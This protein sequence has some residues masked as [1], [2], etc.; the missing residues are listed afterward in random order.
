MDG[1]GE[2]EGMQSRVPV[3]ELVAGMEARQAQG[4]GIGYGSGPLLL[5]P[6][7]TQRRQQGIRAS[8]RVLAQQCRDN[9]V[10]ARTLPAPAPALLQRARQRLE[11]VL[12]NGYQVYGV[13]P[14]VRLLH[15][16]CARVG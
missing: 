4:G 12:Q 3:A 16:A 1:V 13:A 2:R 9:F 8:L 7:L 15:P 14:G 10:A 11:G 5:R 6:A